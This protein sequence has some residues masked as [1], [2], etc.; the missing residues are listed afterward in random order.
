MEVSGFDWL[1]KQTRY[2]YIVT[3]THIYKTNYFRYSIVF[4]L[5]FSNILGRDNVLEPN[6]R[7]YREFYFSF[8]IRLLE[9]LAWGFFEND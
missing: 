2:I 4:F 9:C 8:M 7:I 3:Y 1:L 5:L 6:Y